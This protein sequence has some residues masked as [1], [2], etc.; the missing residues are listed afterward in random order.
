ML[1]GRLVGLAVD[2]IRFD[3]LSAVIGRGGITP[4]K[5]VELAGTAPD[6]RRIIAA[7]MADEATNAAWIWECL[8]D[9]KVLAVLASNGDGGEGR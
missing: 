5:A 4:E 7:S 9:L 2:G 8:Q 1:I 3:A 6:I